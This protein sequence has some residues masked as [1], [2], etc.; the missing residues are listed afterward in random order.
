MSI[1]VGQEA[2]DFA[3]KDQNG[4]VRR[5]SDYRGKQSVMLV[6]FPLAFSG[7]CTAELCQLRDDPPA[8]DNDQVAT[9]G[10][11][12]DSP[13]VQKA[14]AEKQGY[15]FPLLSDFW[16]HGDV[17]RRYGVFNDERG[18]ANRGTFIVDKDGIVRYETVHQPT[19]P[20]DPDEYRRVLAQLT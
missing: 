4:Q 11:S 13:Y 12:I 10:I 9:M 5:L 17:A 3:L 1:Q 8:F 6:F 2:P 19:E 16:P 18:F 14:C 20:R 15:T 7:I